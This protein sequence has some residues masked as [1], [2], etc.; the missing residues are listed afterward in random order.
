MKRVRGFQKKKKP[1]NAMCKKYQLGKMTNS[2]FKRKTYS[3]DDILELVH[4]NLFEPIRF[5]SNY[6]DKYFILF[7]Y[8]YSRMITVLKKNLMFFSRLRCIW[9]ELKKR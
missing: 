2:S 1:N 3:S 9:P 5:Q 4:T 6:G 7:F 8:D